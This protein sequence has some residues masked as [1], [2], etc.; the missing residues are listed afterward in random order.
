[1][2]LYRLLL[3]LSSCTATAVTLQN[4]PEGR[5][6]DTQIDPHS[7]HDSSNTADRTPYFIIVGVVSAGECIQLLIDCLSL[8][9]Q[10]QWR[11]SQVLR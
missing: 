2:R 7:V 3:L 9:R 11:S 6:N 5:A 10:R 4:V 8:V 1:M